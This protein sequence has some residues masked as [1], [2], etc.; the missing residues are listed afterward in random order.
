M[1]VDLENINIIFE[2]QNIEIDLLNTE[3]K[4]VYSLVDQLAQRI[5]VLESQIPPKPSKQEVP[6]TA[7]E[8]P[9]KILF[10]GDENL[11]EVKVSDVNEHVSVGT[12]NDAN[13][14]LL[15]FWVA[16][17]LNMVPE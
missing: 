8:L 11:T 17:R 14:D 1:A 5:H 13:T 15:R 12:I 2:T 9:K 7:S 6:D 3:M 16:E 4:V 10:L